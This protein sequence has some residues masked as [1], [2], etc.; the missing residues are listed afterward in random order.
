MTAAW[1]SQADPGLGTTHLECADLAPKLLGYIVRSHATPLDHLWDC[2]EHCF[3]QNYASHIG[4]PLTILVRWLVAPLTLLLQFRAMIMRSLL[5]WIWRGPVRRNEQA[6]LYSLA[7]RY[8]EQV[9]ST[10]D[11]IAL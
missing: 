9:G 1:G 4:H 11:D 10:P 3:R 6:K 2:G 8:P 5:N 7:R